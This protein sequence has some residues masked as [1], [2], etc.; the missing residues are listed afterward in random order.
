[1]LKHQPTRKP[2][3]FVRLTGGNS[4]LDRVCMDPSP[5]TALAAAS[6]VKFMINSFALFKL[7]GLNAFSIDD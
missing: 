5:R 3:L 7:N 1:M 4:E 2:T 6:A